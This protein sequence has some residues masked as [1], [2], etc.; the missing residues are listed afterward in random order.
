MDN[1]IIKIVNGKKILNKVE[2]LNNINLNLEGGKIYGF[3]GRNGSGKTMLFKVISSLITL[4][5]GELYIYGK[6]INKGDIAEDLGIIIETPGFLENLSG[7]ENLKLLASIRNVISD[8]QIKQAINIVDLNPNDK[9]GVKKYSLGMKQRL[10][11]AQAIM[12]N[13]RILILDEPMNGLDEDGV[14]L[15]RNLLKEKK[16]E[17]ITILITSHNS[18]DINYLCDK[19]YKMK[20]GEIIK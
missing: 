4:T 14:D 16:K 1:S 9:R 19:I 15:V 13:P 12:E 5:D 18:E 17:G 20:N 3:I 6:K 7:F 11:I 8:E 2:V 10:G